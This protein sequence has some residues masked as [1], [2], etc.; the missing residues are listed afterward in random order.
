MADN[1]PIQDK[2]ESVSIEE[3]RR[4]IDRLTEFTEFWAKLYIMASFLI[5]AFGGYM[6]CWMTA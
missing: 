4:T 3:H 2:R 6:L 1:W 5:G